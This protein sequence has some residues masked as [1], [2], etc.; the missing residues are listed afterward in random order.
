MASS[1]ANPRKK[2]LVCD[3]LSFKLFWQDKARFKRALPSLADLIA[4]GQMVF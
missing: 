3:Q 1:V 4:F 2:C